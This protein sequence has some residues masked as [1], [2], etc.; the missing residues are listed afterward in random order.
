[1]PEPNGQK[2]VPLRSNF[3][4]PESRAKWEAAR[5]LRTAQK[6]WLERRDLLED[7][8]QFT[9]K[10]REF[11]LLRDVGLGDGGDTTSF[12]IDKTRKNYKIP[13]D[14]QYVSVDVVPD[15]VNQPHATELVAVDEKNFGKV[16]NREWLQSHG[17]KSGDTH[18]LTMKEREFGLFKIVGINSSSTPSLIKDVRDLCGV[19]RDDQNDQYAPKY[20]LIDIESD[21]PSL[22]NKPLLVDFTEADFGTVIDVNADNKYFQNPNS[23][24]DNPTPESAGAYITVDIEKNGTLARSAQGLQEFVKELMKGR[25]VDPLG[26]SFWVR[27]GGV[28]A[29]QK[30]AYVWEN[31]RPFAS[32]VELTIAFPGQYD[33]VCVVFGDRKPPRN[34]KAGMAQIQ[35]PVVLLTVEGENLRRLQEVYGDLYRVP[36]FALTEI[37]RRQRDESFNSYLVSL[38]S[39]TAREN[40]I[41]AD[42]KTSAHRARQQPKLRAREI[43][44]S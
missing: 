1:M 33:S 15:D 37:Q 16:I 43:P 5:E 27:A 6:G 23:D 14:A 39:K 17:I 34:D 10:E 32:A 26:G 36:D 4:D 2:E 41:D 22:P 31:H 28:A 11:E 21:D 24:P 19:P 9:M 29:G 30:S 7:T 38:I 20:A 44:R 40:K 42:F 8:L 25:T 13:L 3:E 12:L 18:H 35:D